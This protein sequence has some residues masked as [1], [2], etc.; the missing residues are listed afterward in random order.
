MVTS[1]CEK[2]QFSG[3]KSGI[4]KVIFQI[5]RAAPANRAKLG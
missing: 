3:R 5:F 4:F 1:G 2:T